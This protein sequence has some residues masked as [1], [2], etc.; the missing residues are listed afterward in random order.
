[1]IA[2]PFVSRAIMYATIAAALLGALGMH[3]GH[4]LASMAGR[5]RGAPRRCS[6]CTPTAKAQSAAARGSRFSAGARRITSI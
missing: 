5:R 1:M 3:N 2:A 6:R 4:A